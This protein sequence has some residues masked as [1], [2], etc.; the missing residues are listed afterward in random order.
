MIIGNSLRSDR[1]GMNPALPFIAVLILLVASV[2]VYYTVFDEERT[3]AP[4]SVMRYDLS[5]MEETTGT[6]EILAQNSDRYVYLYSV[7]PFKE[8]LYINKDTGVPDDYLKI[9]DEVID[10]IDGNKKVELLRAPSSFMPVIFYVDV[11]TKMIYKAS[12]PGAGLEMTLSSHEMLWQGSYK[13]S[14]AI[15]SE[16]YY[17]LVG[18]DGD[19]DLVGDAKIICGAEGTDIFFVEL[20]MT[21]EGPELFVGITLAIMASTPQGLPTDATSDGEV[22]TIETSYGQKEVTKWYYEN[23]GERIVCYVGQGEDTIY[24]IDVFVDDFE[25][26]LDR[27]DDQ[28]KSSRLGRL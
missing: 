18:S 9:G 20:D 14:Q 15:G 23:I 27:Y 11:S 25:F 2:G 10:T 1:K 22:I 6:I 7:G 17:S 5:G 3:M 19:V 16:F 4:G 24:K 26:T 13:E 12:E 21:A 28:K 8:T